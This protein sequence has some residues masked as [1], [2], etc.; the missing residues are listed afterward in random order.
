[1]QNDSKTELEMV[2]GILD[3]TY[4]IEDFR[5]NVIWK[6]F[7]GKYKCIY[8]TEKNGWIDDTYQVIDKE[9]YLK[10]F[11]MI[12]KERITG[13][14]RFY[15]LKER[16]ILRRYIKPTITKEEM[17]HNTL[18]DIEKGYYDI[19]DGKINSTVLLDM[20]NEVF[21][22]SIF[23]LDIKYSNIINRCKRESKIKGDIIYKNKECFYNRGKKKKELLD[24]YYN[25]ELSVKNNIVE[26]KEKTGI[27]FKDNFV[28]KWLKDKGITPKKDSKKLVSDDKIM[29]ELNIEISLRKNITILRE[30]GIKCKT[31]RLREL[32]N[33]KKGSKKYLVKEDDITYVCEEEIDYKIS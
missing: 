15:F 31:E 20:I 30:K 6:T 12:N 27:E 28:R 7:R 19:S 1:M 18:C 24:K 23:E 33:L 4:N 29:E 17:I 21:N 16:M 14:K 8:R 5:E 25:Q 10:L 32:F 11:Y 9:N 22:I 3:N 13:D 26:L 2:L